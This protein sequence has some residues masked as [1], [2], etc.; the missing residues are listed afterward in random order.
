[1]YARGNKVL[2]RTNSAESLKVYR[3]IIL[4]TLF[5]L[6]VFSI[7]FFLVEAWFPLTVALIGATTITPACWHLANNGNHVFGRAL[8]LLSCCSYV[9]LCSMGCDNQISAQFYLISIAIGCIVLFSND[10]RKWSYF[11]VGSIPIFWFVTL[12]E[13]ASF[14][15]AQLIT[16]ELPKGTFQNLSFIGALLLTI[17]YLYQHVESIRRQYTAT[18]METEA[19]ALQQEKTLNLLTRIANNVPGV[20]YQFRLSADGRASFPYSSLGINAIY[21]VSPDQVKENADQVFKVLHPEDLESVNISIQ[22]SA[23]KLS[24]WQCDYRVKFEDG[25]I[26]W[27]R[28]LAQPQREVDGS[29]LWHG[30]IM[31]IT[32]EKN[33]QAELEQSQRTAVHA[34]RL[35]SLGEMAGGIA[36][37]INNPLMIITSR[38]S[39]I[40]K[41]IDD[42]STQVDRIQSDLEK[43]KQT[44]FRIAKIVKGLL[45]FA[46]DGEQVEFQ[47]FQVESILNDVS[48]LCGEKAKAGGIDIQFFAENNL[49]VFGNTVQISQV[50]LNLINNSIDATS[51]LENRWIK[52]EVKYLARSNQI[53]FSVT[54]SG[55][56]IDKQQIGKLMQP[57]FTTKGVGK[58]TG[59]GLSV[60]KGLIENHGGVLTYDESSKNTRFYFDIKAS[61]VAAVTA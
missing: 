42:P 40:Q 47:N 1:M 29:T 26:E 31:D 14:L 25:T 59:L 45:T 37:E 9:S 52:V 39:L 57:F 55:N 17:S 12:I 16:R 35:A 2:S 21:H 51:S 53:R 23:A 43:V 15:P 6:A 34:S 48:A 41:I 32:K 19:L 50:I 58:G 36:H 7:A 10:E 20:V 11:L 49:T 60:S 8:F 24:A 5:V 38:I 56:G 46:R 61:D 13:A 28:G 30:F 44:T 3:F 33:L 54:D 18:Q 4:S 27:R 22:D